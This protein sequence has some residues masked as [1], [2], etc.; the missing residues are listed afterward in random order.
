MVKTVIPRK[1][2]GDV[3]QI[4]R[5]ICQSA[6]MYVKTGAPRPMA[7]TKPASVPQQP[8]STE[9]PLDDFDDNIPF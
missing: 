7:T 4:L 8:K 5:A 2:K 3:L 1:F 9:P 6:L